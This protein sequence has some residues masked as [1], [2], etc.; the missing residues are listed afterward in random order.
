V[1]RAAVEFDRTGTAGVRGF[2]PRA[3]ACWR[4][5][6]EDLDRWVMGQRPA[7]VRAA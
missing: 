6:A 7:R 1:R 4:F 2:Q 5:K 3:H